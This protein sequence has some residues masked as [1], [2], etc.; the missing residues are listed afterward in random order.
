MINFLPL[1]YEDELF[2]SIV[3]RYKQM[4][5]ISSKWAL[6]FDL[7]ERSKR[8]G[9]KSVLFP[10]NLNRFINN[11][12]PTSLLTEKGIIS[13]HTM[14]PFYTAFLSKEKTELV[15][16]RMVEGSGKSIE[17]LVGLAGSKV[18]LNNYLK[19]CPLCFKEDMQNLGESYFRRLPQVPG[20]LYCLKHQVLYKNSIVLTTDS[21]MEY[22]CC[23]ET[24]CN[25]EIEEDLNSKKVKELNLKYRVF[26]FNAKQY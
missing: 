11:L 21:Q 19:Y 13:K 5:G 6:E 26:R 1:I 9:R 22:L 2:Y 7:F 20:V 25:M 3:S 17:N 12:P 8:M 15:Y 4:S 23:D 14:F 16:L 10:Q 18:K 24:T